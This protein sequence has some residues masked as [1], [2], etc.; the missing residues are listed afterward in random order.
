MG[1]KSKNA[2]LQVEATKTNTYNV[3][4]HKNVCVE[5]ASPYS[6]LVAPVYRTNKQA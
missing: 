1:D 2:I 6:P 4:S 5:Y 3:T